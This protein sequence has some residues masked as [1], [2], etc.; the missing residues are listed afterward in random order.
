RTALLWRMAS[1]GPLDLPEPTALIEI[2]SRA[3]GNVRRLEGAMTRV[4]ALSSMLSE[5]VTGSLVKK[6]L[7]RG[8]P[9]PSSSGSDPAAEA[10]EAP[11]V[12]AIQ[13]AV[14]SVLQVSRED[15]LSSTRTARVTRARQLAIYLARDL[16]SLS[17][18]QIAR[19]FNRDHSTVLH[20]TRVVS[21]RLDPDSETTAL[22]HKARALLTAES[23]NL[24]PSPQSVH[25]I[26]ESPRSPSTAPNPHGKR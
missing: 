2:A 17:L 8:G 3:G 24:P 11:G 6:A 9:S 10:G 22:L 5:P 1:E 26:Q 19:E 14:C 25:R 13:A 4:T 21:A 20:A 7:D 23:I 18:A 15:L 12:A 16:T